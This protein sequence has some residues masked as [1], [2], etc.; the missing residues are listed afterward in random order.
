MRLIP[1]F[2]AVGLEP[3]Q[4]GIKVGHDVIRDNVSGKSYVRRKNVGGKSRWFTSADSK[5]MEKPNGV[6]CSV[7]EIDCNAQKL[8]LQALLIQMD[9]KLHRHKENFLTKKKQDDGFPRKLEESERALNMNLLVYGCTD[10]STG[11]KRS[12]ANRDWSSGRNVFY[13]TVGQMKHWKITNK[14]GEVITIV[15]FE[16]LVVVSYKYV[17]AGSYYN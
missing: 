8:Y 10:K 1:R 12:H 14:T 15:I 2:S 16:N 13:V 3:L 4:E 17:F 6:I 9:N 11:I 5:E 7:Q